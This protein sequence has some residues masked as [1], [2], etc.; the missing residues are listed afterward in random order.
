MGRVWWRGGRL[1][2]TP[3]GVERAALAGFVGV[4]AVNLVQLAVA[5]PVVAGRA[6][7]PLLFDA[8]LVAFLAWSGVVCGAAIRN[9]AYRGRGWAWADTAVSAGVL[10][11]QPLFTAPADRTGSW[12]AWGFACTLGTAVGAA[13][14][15]ARRWEIAAV[16]TVLSGAYAGSGLVGVGPGQVRAT[17]L[18]NAFAYAGFAV[19]ARLVVGYLRR[20]AVAVEEARAAAAAAAAENARLREIRRQQLLLHD[21]IGVLRLLADPGLPADIRSGLREQAQEM[22]Y[23][24]RAFLEE[25]GRAE[26]VPPADA[27][28]HR[29][30]DAVRRALAEYR[31]LPVEAS[32]DLAD[33]VIVSRAVADA[34]RGAV[35]TLLANV[36]LHAGAGVVVVH[37]DADTEER[38]WEVTVADDGRGFDPA[39]TARG[40]GL[41]VQVEQA[42]SE[43][44]VAAHLHSHV[45]EGTRVTLRGP[46][47]QE[48]R[49]KPPQDGSMA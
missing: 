45:G 26:T 28:E 36:R 40:F 25:T 18:G 34:V 3:A 1:P 42:L 16:V 5:L 12:A 4:R 6:T 8:V 49:R 11:T 37:A 30:T 7:R 9:G 44:G 43:H 35:G 23:R 15:F 38:E 21:N 19:V 41:A 33:D 39:L 29:L 22:M 27:A 14:A 17:V 24:I 13:I 46:L 31:D 48:P 32:L 47:G 10:L 20:L 2:P